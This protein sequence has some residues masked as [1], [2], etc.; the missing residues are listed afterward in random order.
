MLWSQ[1]SLG[2]LFILNNLPIINI[3]TQNTDIGV[4]INFK[5]VQFDKLI[6]KHRL[7]TTEIIESFF[8][9]FIII[10]IVSISLQ[11]RHVLPMP[12]TNK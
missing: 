7:F 10:N 12:P 9:E 5:K 3:S 8:K 6:S 4:E 1:L 11:F 2:N